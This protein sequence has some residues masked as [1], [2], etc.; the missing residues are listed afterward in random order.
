MANNYF[1]FKQFRILQDKCAMKVGT[2]GVLLGAWVNLSDEQTILDIGT[3]TGL[4]ALMLAQRSHAHVDA[5]ESEI[6]ASKQ[7]KE[8]VQRSPWSKRIKIYHQPV[9]DF[10]PG[11]KYDLIITNPPYFI[12]SKENPDIN[13]T[14]ARHTQT[15]SQDQLLSAVLR[16][17]KKDGKLSIILPYVEGKMF[18]EA[19]QKKGLYCSRKTFVKPTPNK[20]PKRLMLEFTFKK[21]PLNEDYLVIENNKRH[22][23]SK[24][25]KELTKEF[26]L[27]F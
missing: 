13:K 10:K 23:Y 24:E 7:A 12:N 16:L 11:K 21:K 17:L 2:D 18:L 1:Q 15:L 14:Q 27:N 20:E 8:N 22:H 19:A 6:N 3:G 5:V 26:Y 9:Q 25:Y 4:I